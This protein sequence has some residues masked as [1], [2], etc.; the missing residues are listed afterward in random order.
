VFVGTFRSVSRKVNAPTTR[1]W[2]NLLQEWG[3]FRDLS[4]EEDLI[5]AIR[6]G[7]DVDAIAACLALA[8]ALDTARERFEATYPDLTK[9]RNRLIRQDGYG[10]LSWI[11]W[12]ADQRTLRPWG[13]PPASIADLRELAWFEEEWQDRAQKAR[14]WRKIAERAQEFNVVPDDEAS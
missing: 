7:R 14:G 3:V 6:E 9:L 5:V 2:M 12:A 13:D 8:D 4:P 11:E 10:Y 1:R